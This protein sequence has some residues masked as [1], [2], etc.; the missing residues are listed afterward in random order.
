VRYLDPQMKRRHTFEAL[1]AL[2]A[3]GATAE[4]IVFLYEDLHWIDKASEDYLAYFAQSMAGL[5]VLLLTTHRPGYVVRWADRTWYTQIA[6][7]VMSEGEAAAV[8]AGVL[9]TDKVPLDLLVR[10]SE[11]SE[12]NPLA[13]EEITAS[14]LER[15]VLVRHAGGV[16]WSGNL[17]VGFPLTIQDIVRARIDGLEESLKDTVQIA[18][19]VG[20]E[21]D[22]RL[23]TRVTGAP[24]ETEQH[25]ATLKRLEL[26]HETR[27]FPDVAFAF[28]HAVIQDVVYQ[29]LLQHRRSELHAAIGTA[30]E[31]LHG[32][33]LEEHAGLLAHHYGLA[34]LHQSAQRYA[35]NAGDR[36]AR[37]LARVEARRYYDQALGAARSLPLAPDRERAEIDLIVKLAAIGVT[38]EE[39]A[40]D[41]TN[42]THALT[43]ARTLGDEPRTAQVLYWLGRIHY[44]TGN[45][46]QAI[47]HA[48]QALAI[49]DR[50]GDEAL[51]APPV[52]LMGRAYYLQSNFRQASRMME[53]SV[54][55]M[56]RLGNAGEEATAEGWVGGLLGWMGEFDR[57]LPYLDHGLQLAREIDNPFV[58]AAAYYYRGI[59]HEQRGAPDQA[60]SDYAEAR[61]LAE[62]TGDLFRVYVTRM[63]EGQAH[64]LAGNAARGREVLAEAETLA[65]QLGTRF[66]VALRK[67]YLANCMLAQG[68]R[69]T[70]PDVCREA[71]ALA[72]E[73]GDVYANALAH[74]VL[75][76]AL[77]RLD[78][79]DWQAAEPAVAD[80]IRVQDELGARPELAR[81]YRTWS[82]LLRIRGDAE[83]AATQFMRAVTMFREIRMTLDL[84]DAE[85]ELAAR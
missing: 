56:R 28:K 69:D 70:V 55:Q 63:F 53:R 67:T 43:L 38:R 62:R 74:R 79:P 64:T 15:G 26:V 51:A 65:S 13:L 47:A 23:L 24:A 40:R 71:I 39:I 57:G 27:F 84:A 10:I 16:R 30:I 61:R 7:D 5:P 25:L 9:R 21:F 75:A 54:E 29:S 18:S 49:A 76:D 45:T 33:R 82:R 22:V 34:A 11:K 2:T 46:A 6:L 3:A 31:E 41:Q 17:E 19:A 32:D 73:T 42:L 60:L 59:I 20:R 50:L 72:E 8:V 12:G 83:A 37:L 58:E 78:P 66:Y 48:E 4:P 14:L 80:A 77:L 1:R 85:R 81:S 52:N 36:A 35:T 44:V 68:E